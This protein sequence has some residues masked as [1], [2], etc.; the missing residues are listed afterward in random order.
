FGD[1]DIKASQGTKS[2]RKTSL[3]VEEAEVEPPTTPMAK[4]RAVRVTNIKTPDVATVGDQRTNPNAR[5]SE[6]MRRSGI[7]HT[8]LSEDGSLWSLLV[9]VPSRTTK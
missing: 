9:E 5:Y 7:P 3:A 2:P 4:H 8:S 1:S 6:C